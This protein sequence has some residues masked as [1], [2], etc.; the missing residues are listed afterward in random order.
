MPS[1]ASAAAATAGEENS[2]I[3]DA[4]RARTPGSADLAAAAREVFPSGVT[5]D[6]RYLRP[7]GLHVE[8]AAGAH[9]WDV[10]GNRYVDY[11]GGHGA[12]LLGHSHPE[13]TAAVEAALADGTHFAAGHRHEIRWA[14]KVIE[15]VP[16][17]ERVRFTSSGTEATLMALRLARAFTGR[18]KMVRFKGHFHGWHDDMTTG[19]AS[20]F[21]GSAVVG[22]PDVVARNTVLLE[23]GDTAALS[24]AFAAHDDIAAAI[25]EPLGA[26][27]GRA[28][29]D[30]DFLAALREVT[31]AH[32]AVLIF[33]E[34]MTGFRVAPGGVQEATGIVPDLTALSKILAGGLPGG[35]VAGRRDILDGLDFQAM[36][37]AGREKIY[38]PGTFNANP[39][40]AIA[41]AKTLEVLAESQACAQAADTA[42]GL[43]DALNEVLRQTGTPWTVYGQSS[44]F[45]IFLNAERRD[46]APGGALPAGIGAEELKANPPELL[47]KLRLAMLANGVDLSGWPGGLVSS[48]HGAE[49][50]AATANAFQ[51]STTML[52]R[53]GL[54]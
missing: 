28:P 6:S 2:L 19:Y 49:D 4:Y 53:E 17:A 12:L 23:A 16:S 15:L 40:S 7:H 1:T 50:V 33:D 9:K 42:R 48:A 51:E 20:H 26:G 37:A 38:H 46:I 34:V 44:A 30:A 14:E 25:I 36:A 32:G 54:I 27:T 52:T 3:V 29:V 31:A 8:R 18:A 24:A 10:D 5:H 45:H 41:G 43:R 21:D 13:V 11:F 39:L 47:R 22:V 35:A